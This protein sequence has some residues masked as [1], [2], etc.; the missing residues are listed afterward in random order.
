MRSGPDRRPL[1]SS[2][3]AHGFTASTAEAF[4]AQQPLARLITPAE[5]AAAILWVAGARTQAV[6]GAV[7]PV[8]GGL[9]L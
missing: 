5:V 3:R 1:R 4:S 2:T 9:A 6:T 7:V 8:D